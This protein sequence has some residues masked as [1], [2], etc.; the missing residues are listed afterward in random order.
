MYIPEI[1]HNYQDYKDDIIHLTGALPIAC[2]KNKP[3]MFT[4]HILCGQALWSVSC[5][6]LNFRRSDADHLT[7]SGAGD[8]RGRLT[9]FHRNTS[10]GSNIFITIITLY[11]MT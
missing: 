1:A 10:Y 11:L 7:G 8:M 2:L 3:D 6:S 4:V 9:R 5:I